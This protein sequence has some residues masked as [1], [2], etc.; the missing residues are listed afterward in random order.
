MKPLA[1]SLPHAV[2]MY[3]FPEASEV[4]AILELGLNQAVAGNMAAAPALNSMAEQIHA[5]MNKYGYTT[6]KLPPL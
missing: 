1:E 6:A 4:I 2:S 5:V 3:Q